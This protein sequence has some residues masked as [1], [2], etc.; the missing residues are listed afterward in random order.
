MD[1][2]V[3][4]QPLT[5]QTLERIAAMRL[6]E[7]LSRVKAAGLTVEPDPALPS[8]LACRC[9]GDP[10]GARALRRLIQ[11]SILDPAAD[12]LL[13]GVTKAALTP[14]GLLASARTR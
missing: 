5:E 13:Q 10:G 3:A 12:L 8:L 1:A 7:A 6:R 4:F 11:S 9:A 14:A 2:V